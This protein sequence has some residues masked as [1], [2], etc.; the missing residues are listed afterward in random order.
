M[1]TSINASEYGL[2]YVTPDHM[3][4]FST[5][6]AVIQVDVSTLRA[7][8]RDWW[9]IWITPF[10]ENVQLTLDEGLPDLG[11]LPRDAIHIRQANFNGKTMF[12]GERITDFERVPS[13]TIGSWSKTSSSP[14]AARRDKFELRISSDHIRFGMPAYDVWWIDTEMPE[15]RLDQRCGADRPP[16]IH[17]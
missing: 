11:G 8:L 7:G 14:D 9:D 16:F 5:G 2:I 6:E 12:I 17:P 10:D 3:V 13:R 4:D 1:M 15:P